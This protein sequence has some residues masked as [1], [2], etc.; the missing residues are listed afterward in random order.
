MKI[1]LTNNGFRTNHSNVVENNKNKNST[2]EYIKE[3]NKATLDIDFIS[4]SCNRK[5]KSLIKKYNLPVSVINKPGKSISNKLRYNANLNNCTCD[6]CENNSPHTCLSRHVVY[7][8]MCSICNKAY[9]G[10]TSRPIKSRFHEH[11]RS[12]DNKDRHSALSEHIIAEHRNISMTISDFHLDILCQ[13]STPVLA[14]TAESRYI[15]M[16]EPEINRKHELT[17]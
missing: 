9:I 12:I 17:Y 3:I 4:D 6:I 2:N 1:R 7:R 11:K 8:F 13:V 16:L 5:I 10:Q 14:R 15:R